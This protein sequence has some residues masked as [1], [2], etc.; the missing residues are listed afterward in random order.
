MMATLFYLPLGSR[1][2][3]ADRVERLAREAFARGRSGAFAADPSW[4]ALVGAPA[5]AL[6]E[7]LR[8]LGLR[9]ADIG[10]QRLY[11]LRPRDRRQHHAEIRRQASDDSS[12]FASLAAL[13]RR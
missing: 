1:F 9:A 8:A 5:D 4:A 3:R 10:E 2:V 12:P 6:D 13:V 11:A 7:M